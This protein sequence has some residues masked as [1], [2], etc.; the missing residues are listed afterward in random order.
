M[1]A[2]L[3]YWQ[4][5][6]DEKDFLAYLTTTGNIVAMPDCRVKARAE[7]APRPISQYV[8][9][10]DPNQFAFGLEHHALAADIEPLEKEGETYLTVAYMSPC[11][12]SYRRGR[13]RDGNKL[14]QSNLAAYWTYP[15]KE[16]RTLLTKDEHFIKWAKKVFAWVRKHTPEQIECNRYPYRAT[17]RAKHSADT[18]LIEAVLY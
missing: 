17:K 10:V 15:D 2:V 14:G 16:A 3:T 13:M 8:R 6:E 11:L 4:T 5:Q 12:I 1:P 7:L 9:H 18:G